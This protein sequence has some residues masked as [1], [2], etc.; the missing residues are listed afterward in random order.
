MFNVEGFIPKLCQL[1]QEIGEDDRGLR[2]RSAGLQALASMV[3]CLHIGSTECIS[4][5]DL[6][7]TPTLVYSTI[8]LVQDHYKIY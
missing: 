1:G 8:N 6:I 4:V 7:V 3:Q 5:V 2:L